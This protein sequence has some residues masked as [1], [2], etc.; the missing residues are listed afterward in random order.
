MTSG[1]ATHLPSDLPVFAVEMPAPDLS[2]YIQG[3]TGITGF[4]S[5]ESGT[6]GP[7][8]VL[9]S[10]IHGNEYVGATILA[11]LLASGFQPLR[12]K[13]TIGFANLAAFARFDPDNP[14]ASRYI[15]EDMNRVWDDFSLF[16][17]RHSAELDRARE[18]KPIIDSADILLDLHSMLWP[19]DPL[20]L[21]GTSA[22][23][24]NLGLE[25]GT[26][27]LV[28]A[29]SGHVNG[30]RL[31]DYGHFAENNQKNVTALLLEAGLH[32]HAQTARQCRRSVRALLRH[33]GMLDMPA[34]QQPP[35]RAANVVKTVT[36]RTNRFNFIREFR[37]GEVIA[38]AGTLIAHDGDE[39]IYTPEDDLIMI[40]PSLKVGYGHT[41]VR[42]A[43]Q[44]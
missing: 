9:V 20:L 30:K 16:G 26:P 5:L 17:I 22:R 4:T 8:V 2:P 39:E 44:I 43:K 34:R 24:R 11:E 32:W 29:D 21:C 12:G 27:G 18:I 1:P 31:I 7:H 3:N 25:M 36:A 37:G 28:V 14:T 40:M 42:L 33:A 10:L 19:S 13:L 15:D 6:D 35:A 23:A 41:A 38:K